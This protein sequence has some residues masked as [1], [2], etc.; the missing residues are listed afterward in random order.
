MFE[1][2]GS[3]AADPSLSF[4]RR[5]NACIAAVPHLLDMSRRPDVMC[6]CLRMRN[7]M[8]W[9][10][11]AARRTAYAHIRQSMR[12]G[13][14]GSKHSSECLAIVT[15]PACS[16]L[17]GENPYTLCVDPCTAGQPIAAQAHVTIHHSMP[18]PHL[19]SPPQA[20]HV[21]AACPSAGRHAPSLLLQPT[22]ICKRPLHRA[23]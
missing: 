9:Q 22:S 2:A 12:Q 13:S 17:L 18:Q 6:P 1:Q 20:P 19:L 10:P 23:L 4:A 14:Q 16:A 15:L 8:A 11:H 5:G 21:A 3:T 7:G